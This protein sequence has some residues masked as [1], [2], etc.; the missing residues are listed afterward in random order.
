[1]SKISRRYQL[2][3]IISEQGALYSRDAIENTFSLTNPLTT[4]SLQQTEVLTSI[5]DIHDFFLK[6]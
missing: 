6:Y 2:C 1:M 4:A 3:K 5:I